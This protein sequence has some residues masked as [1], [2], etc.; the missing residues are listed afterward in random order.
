V[1][2]R[3]ATPTYRGCVINGYALHSTLPALARTEA[4]LAEL[5]QRRDVKRNPT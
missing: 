2:S 3:L 1:P 4:Y 5:R